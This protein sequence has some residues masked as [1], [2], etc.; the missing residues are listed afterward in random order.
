MDVITSHSTRQ[1]SFKPNLSLGEPFLVTY[2][3]ELQGKSLGNSIQPKN[4]CSNVK[5]RSNKG[6]FFSAS[7]M[8]KIPLLGTPCQT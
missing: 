6:M 1:A 5:Y 8:N 3:F 4:G 2:C 7:A